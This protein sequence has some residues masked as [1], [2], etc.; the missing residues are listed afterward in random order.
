R[1]LEGVAGHDELVAR[2]RVQPGQ[3]PMDVPGEAFLS[4]KRLRIAA[5]PPQDPV[6]RVET[7]ATGSPG[8]PVWTGAIGALVRK[9]AGQTAGLGR[10]ELDTSPGVG[11]F[12]QEM[13]VAGAGYEAAH[14][15]G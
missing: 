8:L 10:V 4:V 3:G 5:M 9:R 14:V 2:R 12:D 13:P 11:R 15:T 7:E 1:Q 6:G